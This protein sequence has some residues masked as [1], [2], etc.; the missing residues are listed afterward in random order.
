LGKAYTYLRRMDALIGYDDISSDEETKPADDPAALKCQLCDETHNAVARC[1]DCQENLCE[2]MAQAHTK[3]KATCQHRVQSLLELMSQ[4]GEPSLE[5]TTTLNVPCPAPEPVTSTFPSL[6]K[7]KHK[8][9]A[10]KSKALVLPSATALLAN[11]P[12]NLLG[13]AENVI[14]SDD[15][16]ELAVDKPGTKYNQVAP[17][18][19]LGAVNAE[20]A[21]RLKPAMSLELQ[22]LAQSKQLAKINKH[23]EKQEK[24]APRSHEP[25]VA[26]ANASLQFAPRQ[27]KGKVN[28]STEDLEG[29]GLKKHKGT[30][31]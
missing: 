29:M 8:K 20:E 28:V 4:S 22:R 2:F 21:F 15:E 23:F 9:K 17:P 11:V 25:E 5:F 3:S 1:L 12:A 13:R 27:I 24:R 16:E 30:P 6:E 14:L 18:L 19:G 10:R 7:K 26:M 31:T